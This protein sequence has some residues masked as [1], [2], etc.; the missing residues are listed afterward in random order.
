[1]PEASR[2]Q[3]A[4]GDWV[5]AGAR[6]F[7]DAPLLVA[8]D[9]RAQ[10]YVET[11]DRVTRLARALTARGLGRGSRV[12]IMATDTVAHVEVVLACF[13]SGATFCDLNYRMK[14]P[15]L[16]RILAA[17]KCD[18][19]FTDA[20]YV[21]L[22][23]E[24]LPEAGAAIPVWTLDGTSP[25][26]ESFESLIESTPSGPDFDA[27]ALGEDIVSIAFTSGTTGNPKGVLQPERM[28]RNIIY[29]GIREMRM[30]EGAFRYAGAP[31]FHISGIGS[32]FYSL[33][34]GAA[35]LVLPQFDAPTVLHWMQHG[36]LTDCTLI[37]TMISA[38][39]D[40]P[41]VGDSD[42]AGMRSI[43]YG[44][45][46]MTPALLRRTIDVFGCELYNGFGA[47]TEAG[48]QTMLYPEDHDAAL[49]GK[50]HLLGSIGKAIMGVDLRLCDDQMRDVPRG[51][52]GE[53]VTRSE[54]VMAGYLDQA[55]LT[56]RSIVDGWFRAGDMAYVDDEGYLFLASRKADMI[57][58]GGENVYPVEI[59]TTLADHPAV[60]EVA[61]V[62][63]EDEH[64]GEVVGAA[65]Q[66][67]AG[68]SVDV[69]ELQQFCR[70]R[71]A[72]YKT[73]EIVRF[74]DVLPKG[75]TGKL[76]KRAITALMSVDTSDGRH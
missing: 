25:D 12:A 20:R 42:Y 30:R 35:V 37:P 9:G 43:L 32:V 61:V 52:I 55:E 73:P 53:I 56:S 50:E 74:F 76:D 51:E 7:G 70:E 49:A 31:L 48:G 21:P 3:L 40:L 38:L 15:E 28:F 45:A 59:E 13:K 72:S 41:E 65:L 44:G 17:A 66:L 29:S 26:N 24:V 62:G 47:G 39:L 14:V 58:R 22:V 10:S 34:S 36:G 68:A 19:V 11:N 5:S 23:A 57:I 6:R 54:T 27:E 69:A 2:P 33:A 1:M 75:D 64:W 60:L 4:V 63:I 67:R 16:A 46:P 18:A 8:A 71:L